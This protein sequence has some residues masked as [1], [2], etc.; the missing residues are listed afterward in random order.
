M[1]SQYRNNLEKGDI[2]KVSINSGKIVISK[3][4]ILEVGKQDAEAVEPFPLT[5]NLPDFH[6]R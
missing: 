2:L 4:D 6:S 5:D 1:S 3:V